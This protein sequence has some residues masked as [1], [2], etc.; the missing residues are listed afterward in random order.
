MLWEMLSNI[1]QRG[2]RTSLTHGWWWR[3]RLS[4]PQWEGGGTGKVSKQDQEKAAES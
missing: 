4:A 3:V 2:T 1:D